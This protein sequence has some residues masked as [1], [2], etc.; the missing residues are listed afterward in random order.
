VFVSPARDPFTEE[1][2][3]GVTSETPTPHAF[4]YL[5]EALLIVSIE[6]IQHHVS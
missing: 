3:V 5:Y 4:D 2:A 1:P 6:I